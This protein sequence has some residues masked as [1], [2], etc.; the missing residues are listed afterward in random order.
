MFE[1][2]RVQREP[3]IRRYPSTHILLVPVPGEVGLHVSVTRKHGFPENWTSI[4]G[5]LFRGELPR[6][7]QIEGWGRE[8]EG[9]EGR[10]GTGIV[11][12]LSILWSS[13][14]NS[15]LMTG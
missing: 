4:L 5:R 14:G 13:G 2:M 9:G 3:R 15:V 1:T 6:L 7:E 8:G 11:C 12:S 10:Y